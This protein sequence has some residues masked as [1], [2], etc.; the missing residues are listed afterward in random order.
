MNFRGGEESYAD[1]FT[2]KTVPAK[3]TDVEEQAV[4]SVHAPKAQQ[5]VEGQL[6]AETYILRIAPGANPQE[7]LYEISS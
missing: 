4:N 6:P 7:A 3:T 1:A 5:V 2:Q